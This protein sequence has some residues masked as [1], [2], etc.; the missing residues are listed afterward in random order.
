MGSL[1]HDCFWEKP[2]KR[3]QQA[4]YSLASIA[5]SASVKQLKRRRVL[6]QQRF[7]HAVQPQAVRCAK[8]TAIC[9]IY[10]IYSATMRVHMAT[11]HYAI[12]LKRQGHKCD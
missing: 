7:T 5:V 12:W 2:P 8:N 10:H 1:Q 4:G 9:E 6:W 3:G 11:A